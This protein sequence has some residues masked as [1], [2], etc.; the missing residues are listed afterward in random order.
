M[1]IHFSPSSN[2]VACGRGGDSIKATHE[3]AQV[4]CK[5]CLRSLDKE[6]TPA[7]N[8]ARRTPNLAELRAAARAAKAAPVSANPVKADPVTIDAVKGNPVK[9]DPVKI[10]PAKANPPTAEVT[11]SAVSVRAAWQKRLEDL[12]GRSRLPRGMARQAYV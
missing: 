3:P 8:L 2:E 1:V 10:H 6:V 4:T 11:K 5:L 9:R 12:P 7:A